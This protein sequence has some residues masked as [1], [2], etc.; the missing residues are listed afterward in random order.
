MG[1]DGGM[2]PSRELPVSISVL[3]LGRAPSS[4]GI[5]P[6]RPLFEMSMRTREVSVAM[7]LDNCPRSCRE[8]RSIDTT[9]IGTAVLQVTPFQLQKLSESL[10]HDARTPLGS[11]EMPDLKQ[12]R[13]CRSSS[14]LLLICCDESGR[15]AKDREMKAPHRKNSA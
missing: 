11:W 15:V 10:R 14:V 8:L 3:S 6:E 13:A 2:L 4:S 1:N 5:F 9:R 7:Q 12:R